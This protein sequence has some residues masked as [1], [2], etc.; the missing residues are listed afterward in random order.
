MC[1]GFLSCGGVTHQHLPQCDSTLGK[2]CGD[3][4]SH[5]VQW[6]FSSGGG[7]LFL[8]C[9]SVLRA[10]PELQYFLLLGRDGGL[11]RGLCSSFDTR[12]SSQLLAWLLFSTC[13]GLLSIYFRGLPLF[14]AE[15]L[16]SMCDVLVNSS[17]LVV[18]ETSSV[19]VE[20]SSVIVTSDSSRVAAKNSV[21]PL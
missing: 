17:L 7:V 15:E 8:S 4:I 1:K 2:M 5:C 16:F 14:A 9:G 11:C 3:I 19:L 18:G 21:V 6:L 12:C 20:V 10:P 13:E